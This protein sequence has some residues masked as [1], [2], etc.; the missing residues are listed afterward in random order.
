MKNTSTSLKGKKYCYFLSFK[1]YTFLAV[2]ISIIVR[3]SKLNTKD[4]LLAYETMLK[5]IWTCGI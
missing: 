3:R 2:E 4:K 1:S 5:F